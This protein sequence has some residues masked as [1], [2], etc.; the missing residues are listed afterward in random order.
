MLTSARL[1]LDTELFGGEQ[2]R[3]FH[4]VK[5]YKHVKHVDLLEDSIDFFEAPAPLRECNLNYEV[6]RHA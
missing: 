1:H 4:L 2:Y 3:Y 5:G 6:Q